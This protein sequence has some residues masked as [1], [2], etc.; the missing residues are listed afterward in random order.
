[1]KIFILHRGYDDGC[2]YESMRND[3]P[4]YDEG[5]FRTFELADARAQKIFKDL[6]EELD[7]D[8]YDENDYKIESEP[9]DYNLYIGEESYYI[10]VIGV[11]L[12]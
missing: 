3:G 7:I 11:E 9:G 2:C 6:L 12:H 4:E 10:T 8:S 5:A 1:M